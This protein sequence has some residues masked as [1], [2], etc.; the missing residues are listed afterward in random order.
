[1]ISCGI[2]D[3]RLAADIMGSSQIVERLDS[4]LETA[5][6]MQENGT[7]LCYTDSLYDQMVENQSFADWLFNPN[8]Q[9]ELSTFKRELIKRIRKGDCIGEAEYEEYFSNIERE[10]R[11]DKL[12]MAIHLGTDNV[13]YVATPESYWAAKQWYLS[14]YKHPEK[15]AADLAECFPNLFFHE[16]VCSSIHTLNGEFLAECKV[17]VQ[18]LK[19]LD[20]FRDNFSKFISIGMDYRRIC[21]EFQE[22]FHIECSPQAGRQSVQNLKF[23]FM[24]SKEKKKVE[25]CCEL[26]TKLKWSDMDRVNQ[27]RIYFH[28]G[29]P[30]IENGK[31]LI[32]H[33]GTHL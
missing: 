6:C 8:L 15:F 28:P 24:H 7:R 26:H 18:H 14:G 4:I 11:S 21:L 31:V 12:T 5:E 30:E 17:I 32:V 23:Y 33:I 20:A 10:K 16:H 1:M 13:L 19:A 22:Q 3:C 27:D 25:L 2:W 9:P 29:K